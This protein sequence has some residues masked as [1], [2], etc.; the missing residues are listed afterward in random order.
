[1]K[2][3]RNA[4]R[5]VNKTYALE[6]CPVRLEIYK[7]DIKSG[8]VLVIGYRTDRPKPDIEH[9]AMNW[10]YQGIFMNSG[11]HNIAYEAYNQC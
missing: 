1:M 3:V 10:V 8:C 5:K 7:W 11:L 2:V 4:I 6:N 9:M